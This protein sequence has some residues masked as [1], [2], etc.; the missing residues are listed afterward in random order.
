MKIYDVMTPDLKTVQAGAT[1]ADAAR[2]MKDFNV[3]ILPVM[4]SGEAIGVITDR[5][6]AVRVLVQGGD[7]GQVLIRQIMTPDVL[8]M[9]EDEDLD[10]AIEVMGHRK[11][12][13]LLVKDRNGRL[14]GIVSAADVAALSTPERVGDLMKV[15]GT[16]YWRKH[17]ETVPPLRQHSFET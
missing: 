8:W 6:L 2:K 4:E 11:I 9:Y 17:L 14:S 16:S 1:A 12:S 5:D 3:G 13:R 15:L 10:D 7:I